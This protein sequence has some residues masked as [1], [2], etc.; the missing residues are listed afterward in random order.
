MTKD[1]LTFSYD[2]HYFITSINKQTFH[3]TILE[4]MSRGYVF[5]RSLMPHS[6]TVRTVQCKFEV[7][8]QEEKSITVN[9]LYF[10]RPFFLKKNIDFCHLL[11][12]LNV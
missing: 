11:Y 5:L 9:P 4:T 1:T 8:V 10:G 2:P 12:F 7:V 3:I 6:T